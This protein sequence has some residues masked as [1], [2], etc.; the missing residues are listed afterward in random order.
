M[1]I[2]KAKK[3]LTFYIKRH[4][5]VAKPNCA[6]PRAVHSG[7]PTRN[8]GTPSKGPS[9]DDVAQ[10]LVLSVLPVA[11]HNSNNAT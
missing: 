5:D 7:R 1:P 3:G 10:N 2:D 4:W 6:R 11:A 8:G 9:A